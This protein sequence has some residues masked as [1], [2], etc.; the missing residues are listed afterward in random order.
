MKI[1]INISKL[2]DSPY[3]KESCAS[4]TF[5]DEDNLEQLISEL[6][7]AHP[8]S[9]LISGYR[10]VGKTSFVNR[11]K[12]KFSNSIFIQINLAKYDGYPILLKKIIRQL[13]LSFNNNQKF[14]IANTEQKDLQKDLGLIY[15][16]TFNDIS[17]ENKESSSKISSNTF[18]ITTDL[19]KI[20]PYLVVAFT[21]LN[22]SF[23]YTHYVVVNVIIFMLTLLW[24]IVNLINFQYSRKKD[25]IL[26]QE[27]VRKSLYDNEIAEYHL[28]NI[29]KKLKKNNVP[30]IIV[31]DELDKISTNDVIDNIINDIKALIL[32]GYANYFVVA[33]QN[34]YYRLEE[35]HTA[36]NNVISSLFAKTIH[37]PFMSYTSLKTHC[38][39]LISDK[40]QNNEHINNYF[41]SLILQ[42]GRVPRKLANLI[43]NDII[44]EGDIPYIDINEAAYNQLKYEA[45]LLEIVNNIIDNQL[46]NIVTNNVV[47]DFYTAQ[48]YIWLKTIMGYSVNKFKIDDIL[49]IETYS[50]NDYPQKFINQLEPLCELFLEKLVHEKILILN[51]GFYLFSNSAHENSSNNTSSFL[52]DFINLEKYIRGIYIDIVEDATWDNI[53][54][55]SFISMV[56]ELSKREFFSKN[57]DVK[58]LNEINNV[59]NKAVHGI[60]LNNQEVKLLD[61][62]Q[63][64]LRRIQH[65]LIE[66]YTYFIAKEF[67]KNHKVIFQNKGLFDFVVEHASYSILFEIKLLTE[68]SINERIYQLVNTFVDYYK[69]HDS[70]TY[71]VVFC[72]HPNTMSVYERFKGTFMSAL[73][74][75]APEL[76]HKVFIYANSSSSTGDASQGRTKHYLQQIIKKIEEDVSS[77][78]NST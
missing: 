35:S 69:A 52:N 57:I 56:S 21:G 74:N 31:F 61:K 62:S 1:R 45:E 42:S 75:I 55:K 14:E 76:I 27:V 10:G 33:G 24:P 46:Q 3:S 8:A 22:L 41:D 51:N 36:D 59:R 32:S 78:K 11:V 58:K 30:I 47:L 19:K 20:V 77:N 26:N 39:S 15:E 40:L 70:N 6:K 37:I 53:A 25:D 4:F 72:Y 43:R 50:P 44:W 67:F 13:Y 2:T 49:K 34:L 54:Q 18:S 12:E 17:F 60:G 66:N 5:E 9:F 7:N 71:L 68:K 28:F 65:A 63:F 29:L 48:I 23:N 16:R 64:N 38:L 73:N